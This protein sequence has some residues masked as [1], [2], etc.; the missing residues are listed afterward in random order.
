MPVHHS[1][2]TQCWI[3]PKITKIAGD[4][5]WMSASSKF[6]C[7]AYHNDL[8]SNPEPRTPQTPMCTLPETQPS[9]AIAFLDAKN[10]TNLELNEIPLLYGHRAAILDLEFDPF[11][12]NLLA[13]CCA[14]GTTKIWHIPDDFK[15]RLTESVQT[16]KGTKRVGCLKYNSICQN[17]LATAAQDFDVV[18]WDVELGQ[19]KLR[20]AGHTALVQSLNWNY[21]GSL[22]CSNSK[23]KEVHVID[24]RSQTI[25]SSAQSHAGVKGGRAI[26]LGKHNLIFTVGFGPNGI[27]RE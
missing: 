1:H 2:P 4:S 22:L 15:G 20:T 23:D 9:N 27:N 25:V 18:I 8:A 6:I 24:P 21:T 5:S 16:L 14:D 11:D 19:E 3:G 7:M 26:W 10:P 17:V 13:T 12:D